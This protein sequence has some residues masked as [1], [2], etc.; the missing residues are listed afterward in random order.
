MMPHEKNMILVVGE[1]LYDVFP[2]FRRIGGAP[3]NFAFHLIQTGFPVKFISRVGTDEDGRLLLDRMQRSGFDTDHIQIDD[4]HQTGRVMVY[5]DQSGGHRFEILQDVAYDYI[6]YTEDV[7]ELL[8]KPPALIYF[9]TLVQRTPTGRRTIDRICHSRS[10]EATVFYDVNLRPGCYDRDIVQQSLSHADILKLNDEELD[11][12]TEMLGLDGKAGSIVEV[13][14]RE[15][16]LTLVA[17]TKG[18]QGS[19]IF[20]HE[21]HIIMPLNHDYDCV[22]TVG[23]GDAFA[24]VLAAGYLRNGDMRQVLAT[25]TEFAGRICGIPG[26]V[27][28]DSGFYGRLSV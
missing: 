11:V 4:V 12:I 16:S 18:A 21:E 27:P 7:P 25:A 23:A 28:E 15:Y 20:T 19:E 13:L 14:M 3:F 22:D 10:P 8:Q 17:L 2:E 1:V 24:A 5:P 26:A 9:G 6:N